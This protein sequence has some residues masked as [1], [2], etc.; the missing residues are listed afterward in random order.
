MYLDTELLEHKKLD[1]V[2][3][4]AQNYLIGSLR[5]QLMA[6]GAKLEDKATDAEF[7]VEA[8][9]G[10]V[11]S[12]SHEVTYGMPANS[13]L[14]S[15]ASFVPNSPPLP[16]IPELS[17]AKQAQE[18]AA[19]KLRLFAYH[20]ERREIVW[21][22]GDASA[23]SRASHTWL[24]GAGPFEKG[25][26]YDGPRFAGDKL[27]IVPKWL[28][29]KEPVA[30]DPI[31]SLENYNEPRVYGLDPAPPPPEPVPPAAGGEVQLASAEKSTDEKPAEKK[32]AEKKPAEKK[33]DAAK[34]QPVADA[35][36]PK[37]DPKPEPTK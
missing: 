33:E 36:P 1:A 31:A 29:K 35:P 10:A 8:R 6:A 20:R 30:H 27:S 18:H 25:Q 14:S 17:V 13:L 32:P 34:P 37:P 3:I 5:Q 7:I 11:G 9:A 4:G 2:G 16:V 23:N 28:R 19:T 22:S 21:Q 24:L 15:A 26:I 12:D